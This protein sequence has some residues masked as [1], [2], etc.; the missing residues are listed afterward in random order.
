M[1]NE[2][3]DQRGFNTNQP[4]VERTVASQGGPATGLGDPTNRTAGTGIDAATQ[5]AAA[6]TSNSTDKKNQPERNQ[7]QESTE[8]IESDGDLELPEGK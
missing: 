7:D 3:T 4:D 5:A 6:S 8:E 2:K 1:P